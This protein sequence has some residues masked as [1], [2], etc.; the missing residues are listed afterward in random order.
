MVHPAGCHIARRHRVHAHTAARPFHGR[1][2]S[3]AHHARARRAA[4]RHAGHRAPDV[5]HDVHDRAAARRHA[6]REALARHE[7][8]ASQVGVDHRL[9]ALGA[10]LL[11][12]GDVLAARVVHQPIDRAV[13]RHDARHGLSHYI[14]LPDVTHRVAG[15][16]AIGGD[17]ILH[18]AQLVGVA[19]NQH[20]ARAQRRQLVRRAAPNARAAARHHDDLT[21]QQ[22]GR[23]D[24]SVTHACSVKSSKACA[25]RSSSDSA[26]RS[27]NHCTDQLSAPKM[28]SRAT[29]GR[30]L[31]LPAR[32]SARSTGIQTPS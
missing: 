32:C 21:C 19:A 27:E 25:V 24:R 2:F 29:S 4:V 20:H 1:R 18:R 13:L 5:G 16:A 14:L 15:L 3:Q 10:D 26:P 7:E 23:E 8:A 28:N 9:P 31:S 17:F 30:A 12:R 6:L 22:A 11:G